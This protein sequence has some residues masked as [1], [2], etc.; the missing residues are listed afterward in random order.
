MINGLYHRWGY[1]NLTETREQVTNMRQ[2][3]IPLEGRLRS[4]RYGYVFLCSFSDF[5]LT[6]LIVIL[7]FP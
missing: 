3:N 2:V 1:K 6:L 4:Y 5:P 7:N